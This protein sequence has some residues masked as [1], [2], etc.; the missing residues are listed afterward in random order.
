[1]APELVEPVLAAAAKSNDETLFA[2]LLERAKAEKDHAKVSRL[3]RALG[4]F[5]APAL[6]RRADGTRRRDHV[7]R[8][9]HV[10]RSCVPQFADPTT[11]QT[12]RGSSSRRRSIPSLPGCG[13]TRCSSSTSASSRASATK[14]TRSEVAEFFAGRAPHFDGGPRALANAVESIG[15]C[16]AIFHENQAEPRR[17]PVEVLRTLVT[18]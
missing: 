7:R 1:M 12:S 10:R 2:A 9:R 4:A 11:Q 3:L 13:A 14:P 5:T 6:V 8:P 16:A 18:A 15:Q 17:V